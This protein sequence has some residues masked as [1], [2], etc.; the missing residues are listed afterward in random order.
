MMAATDVVWKAL[1]EAIPS[2]LAAG[3]FCTANSTLLVP[4]GSVWV[5]RTPFDP[6]P[7]ARR[8]Q[9]I[10]VC[11]RVQLSCFTRA[12]GYQIAPN[13]ASMRSVAVPVP[14]VDSL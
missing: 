7:S 14:G 3:H 5:P 10:F 2:R 12:R 9:S 6:C 8:E 1:A 11:R 4:E 13:L